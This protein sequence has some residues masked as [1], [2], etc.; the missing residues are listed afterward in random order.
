MVLN[1]EIRYDLQVEPFYSPN[2][3]DTTIAINT[4]NSKSVGDSN[5]TILRFLTTNIPLNTEKRR[6]TTEADTLLGYK[7]RSIISNLLPSRQVG[8]VHSAGHL[9]KKDPYEL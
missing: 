8:P 9:H 6:D 2:C 7:L 1:F 3:I 4:T 5:G